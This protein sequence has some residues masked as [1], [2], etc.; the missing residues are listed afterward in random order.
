MR[1]FSSLLSRLLATVAVVA[2]CGSTLLAQ[3]TLGGITGDV[4]DPSGSVIPNATITVLDEQTS[5]TRTV[6]TNGGGDYS[7]VNL[8][9]GSYTVTF[10]V[11]G[12]ETQKTPHIIVQGNRTA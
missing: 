4:T 6:V 2:L 10:A 3:Q 12:F 9:I 5:L 8:P 1:L 11:T 7:F